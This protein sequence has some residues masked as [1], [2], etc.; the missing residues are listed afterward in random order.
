MEAPEDGMVVTDQATRHEVWYSISRWGWKVSLFAM[1][2]WPKTMTKSCELQATSSTLIFY[3]AGES[4]RKPTLLVCNC[5]YKYTTGIR[6]QGGSRIV[7]KKGVEKW[8]GGGHGGIT[9]DGWTRSQSTLSFWKAEDVVGLSSITS[10]DLNVKPLHSCY[11]IF[12]GL[13]T[14]YHTAGCGYVVRSITVDQTPK[15]L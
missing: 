10:T 12:L 11:M 7:T 15:A 13:C 5:M 9:S 8:E 4:F 6:F 3:H 1:K 14:D 2:L